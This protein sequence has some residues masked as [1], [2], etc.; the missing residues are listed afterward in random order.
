MDISQQGATPALL[1]TIT[2]ASIPDALIAGF[3]HSIL[4]KVTG[5]PTFEDLKI[6]RRYLNTNVMRVSSYEGGGRHGHLGIIM[7]NDEYFTLA[8]DVF[9]AADNPEAKPVHPENATAARIAEANLVHTEAT[10]VYR[11]CH[12]VDQGLKKLI[13]EA[14]K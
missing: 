1:T 3:P 8:T 12:N 6:I 2:T 13:L 9:T 14:F 11:T 4:Q 7:T 10:C 5:E